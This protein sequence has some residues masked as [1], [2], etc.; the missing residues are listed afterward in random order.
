MLFTSAQLLAMVV[1]GAS[2]VVGAFGVFDAVRARGRNRR[3][4]CA[5]CGRPWSDAYPEV[6]RSLVSGRETCAWCVAVLRERLPRYLRRLGV[7]AL[8]AVAWIVWELGIAN[9]MP[10]ALTHWALWLSAPLTLTALAGGGL[11]VAKRQNRAALARG[12]GQLDALPPG[13]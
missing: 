6:E 4:C 3:G 7:A 12:A 9:P 1:G 13:A 2:A 8:F 11:A 5:R 10:V